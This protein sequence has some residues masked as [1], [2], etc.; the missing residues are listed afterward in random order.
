MSPLLPPGPNCLGFELARPVTET[1]CEKCS[2]HTV[3]L[4]QRQA[5]AVMVQACMQACCQEC[6]TRRHAQRTSLDQVTKERGGE[7][8]AA[9]VR[10]H[11]LRGGTRSPKPQKVARYLGGLDPCALHMACL[12]GEQQSRNTLSCACS[13]LTRL[14][15]AF[16][17]SVTAHESAAGR[18][19]SRETGC[20]QLPPPL[21]PLHIHVRRAA[22]LHACRGLACMAAHS[23][24]VWQRTARVHCCTFYCH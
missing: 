4:A 13:G 10:L 2:L 24:L 18:V 7:N 20:R 8:G 16:S 22:A 6:P 23:L 1:R 17:A 14:V 3:T 5:A 19:H 21:L 11:A 9:Q 15:T 12:G